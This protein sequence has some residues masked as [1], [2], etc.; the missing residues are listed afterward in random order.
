MCLTRHGL[1]VRK[2]KSCCLDA[3]DGRADG[4]FGRIEALGARQMRQRLVDEGASLGPVCRRL[5]VVCGVARR[6]GA[7]L[8]VGLQQ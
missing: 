7:D 1:S 3:R 2:A 6:C 4:C 8:Q 5:G